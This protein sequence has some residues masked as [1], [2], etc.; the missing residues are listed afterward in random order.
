[1]RYMLGVFTAALFGLSA[2]SAVPAIA[3]Y[4]APP[5]PGWTVICGYDHSLE[6]DPIVSPNQPG[7][8]HLHDFF[9]SHSTDAFSTP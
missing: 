4:P 2:V 6:D 7:A 8:A 9:G 5:G 1:M 3:A